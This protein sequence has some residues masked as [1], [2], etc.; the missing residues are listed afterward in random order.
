MEDP[1]WI[2]AHRNAQVGL[3]HEIV[4][5]TLL[6]VGK[7]ADHQAKAQTARVKGYQIWQKHYKLWQGRRTSIKSVC[8]FGLGSLLS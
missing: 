7:G 5:V 4:E 1:N 2:S 6:G 8:E 3:T